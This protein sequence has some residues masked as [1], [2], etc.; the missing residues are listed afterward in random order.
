MA[1]P[2]AYREETLA[3]NKT[4]MKTIIRRNGHLHIVGDETAD[5]L[6]TALLYLRQH[7]LNRCAYPMIGTPI[8]ALI[9]DISVLNARSTRTRNARTQ[10]VITKHERL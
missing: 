10:T 1:R 2:M 9:P 8:E 3:L 7:T 5:E 4:H 6:R